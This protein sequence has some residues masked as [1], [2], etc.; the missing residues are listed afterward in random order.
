MMRGVDLVLGAVTRTDVLDFF[1]MGQVTTLECSAC[2]KQY[3]AATEQHLCT[4]GKPLLAR[5]DLKHASK[6]LNLEALKGRQRNLWRYFE[7]LPDG[8]AVTLGEG[9]TAL[10]HATRLGSS[11]GLAHLYVKDEGLNPTG[12]F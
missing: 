10:I 6:T 4:C 7:V 1:R 11:M 12:S 5:Y 9:M 2:K 3:D 8:V